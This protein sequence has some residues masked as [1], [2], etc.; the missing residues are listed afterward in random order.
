MDTTD[1]YPTY[2]NKDQRIRTTTYGEKHYDWNLC[3]GCIAHTTRNSAISRSAGVVV[4]G[5]D[6]R[7]FIPEP[8]LIQESWEFIA[9]PKYA[10]G[11]T[12]DLSSTVNTPTNLPN[13]VPHLLII[14]EAPGESED[15]SGQLFFGKSGNLWTR[16]LTITKLHFTYIM[17]NRLCC[18]PTHTAPTNRNTVGSNR[19]PSP[20]EIATC[21]PHINH[22]VSEYKFDGLILLGDKAHSYKSPL[23]RLELVHPSFILRQDYPLYACKKMRDKLVNFVN[24]L[25]LT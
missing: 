3:K 9:A 6:H 10:V 13:Q 15:A 16:V 4:F 1:N 17:T 23:P 11:K 7:I 21:E 2:Y 8:H 19:S 25:K 20:Q 5:V 22:L 18:R 24:S 12:F 14:G